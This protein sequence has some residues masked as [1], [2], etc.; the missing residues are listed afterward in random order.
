L[1]GEKHAPIQFL[2]QFLDSSG[3]TYDLTELKIMFQNY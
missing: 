1:I 3:M 2:R